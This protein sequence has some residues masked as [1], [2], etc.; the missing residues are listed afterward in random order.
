M[1]VNRV[2]QNLMGQGLVRTAGDFGLAGLPPDDPELLDWL[3]S[4]F[5]ENK[6]SVKQLVRK[7][8]LS[9]SYQQAAPLISVPEGL[10]Y[11]VRQPRR[12]R[13]ASS[14]V[15]RCYASAWH[16]DRQVGWSGNLAGYIRREVLEANLGTYWMTTN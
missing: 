2:W 10:A 6:W 16:S 14:F 3:A 7:I 12:L 8:V 5:V 13:R 9:A 15:T 1:F 4:E 11:A